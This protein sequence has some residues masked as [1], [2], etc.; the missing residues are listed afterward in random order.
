LAFAR[1]AGRRLIGVT[2]PDA[3]VIFF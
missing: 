1:R 3:E 2:D